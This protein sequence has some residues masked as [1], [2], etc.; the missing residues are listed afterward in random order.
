MRTGEIARRKKRKKEKSD[1]EKKPARD[2]IGD[3]E[4]RE[5]LR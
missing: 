3:G 5:T 4:K 1:K 2:K